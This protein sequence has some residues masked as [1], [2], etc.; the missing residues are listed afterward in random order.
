MKNLTLY[1]IIN[2][3]HGSYGYPSNEV[4]IS[5]VSTDT[6]DI[7]EN[8]LFVALK[9]DNFDGHNFVL[10]AMEKG[11]VAAITEKHIEGGRCIVVDDTKKAL[12]AVASFYRKKFE[13]PVVAITG[14]VG[15]TTTKDMISL[16][17][18]SEF[19]TLKTKGNLNNEIGLPRTLLSLE[20]E[21]KAAVIEMGMSNFGEISALSLCANPNI[22]VITNIGYS[23]IE[24]LG[25][26][27]GILKAKFEIIDGMSYNSPIIL[28]GD[29]KLLFEKGNSLK[30]TKN[31][32]FYGVTN[33]KCDVL[34]TNIERDG[35]CTKFVIKYGEKNVKVT[36]NVPGKHNVYNALAAFCVGDILGIDENKIAQSL[37]GYV[38]ENLRQNIKEVGGLTLIVD[39]YN[40]SPTSMQSALSVLSQ[41]YCEGRK[42]AVL[43]D[44]FELG[45]MAKTLHKKVGGYVKS[46][47]I[48]KLICV[49]ENAKLIGEKS[50]LKDVSYFED[51]SLCAEYINK[52]VKKG[53]LILFK[54]SRG[55]KFEEI[56]EKIDEIN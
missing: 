38:G 2:A 10:E 5:E 46:A 40:A 36:L 11:A 50:A 4:F 3:V 39:C 43:G 52:F 22:C 42:I 15:K 8:S 55:M 51:K 13:I 9:G 23:H 31:V 45:N 7:K 54:A 48:D 20:S 19:N 21:H 47:K 56:I 18:E 34:A 33:K 6:R 41:K 30:A 24:N 32:I 44:M 14:S 26:Q 49:G 28:N 16:V 35:D 17:L 1:E 53:D 12:M 27:K 29:D 37:G 25:S